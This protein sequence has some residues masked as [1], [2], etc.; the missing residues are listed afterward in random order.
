MSQA[1]PPPQWRKLPD[2]DDEVAL[3]LYAQD[4]VL[5]AAGGADQGPTASMRCT[6]LLFPP[7][8]A[9]QRLRELMGKRS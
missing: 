8:I 6:A 7:R 1:D 9:W 3:D 4:L 2:L 5:R